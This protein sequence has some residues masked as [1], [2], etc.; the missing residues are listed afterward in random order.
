MDPNDAATLLLR[1]KDLP[2][3]ID[4]RLPAQNV[5]STASGYPLQTPNATVSLPKFV[6]Y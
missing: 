1:V 3:S 2:D 6:A 4:L 5:M